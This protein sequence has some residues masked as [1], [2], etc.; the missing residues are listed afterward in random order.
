MYLQPR[1]CYNINHITVPPPG[2]TTT[3]NGF[4]IITLTSGSH[5]NHNQWS[6]TSRYGDDATT[7]ERTTG[8]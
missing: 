4:T 6:N 2:H 1:G 8:S 7:R 5:T 3:V